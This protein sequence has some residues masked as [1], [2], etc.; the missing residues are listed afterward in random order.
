MTRAHG[1]ALVLVGAAGALVSVGY[2]LACAEPL[3]ATTWTTVQVPDGFDA[4][5]G[6]R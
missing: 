3:P 6:G 2:L 1:W 5:R 4:G